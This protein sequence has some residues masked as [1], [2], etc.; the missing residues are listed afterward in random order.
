ML[1]KRF[2][3]VRKLRAG[4][5]ALNAARAWAM[6]HAHEHVLPE[7]LQ[8]VLPSV[9]GHRLQFVHEAD[10]EPKLTPA[11]HLIQSVAIP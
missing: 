1:D 6:L 9:I 2:S 7:D 11:Q 10:N 4:L 3:Q 5:C 8:A